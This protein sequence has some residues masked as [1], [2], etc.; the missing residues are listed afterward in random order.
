M[1]TLRDCLP[2]GRCKLPAKQDEISSLADLRVC[3]GDIIDTESLQPR[4]PFPAFRRR[5]LR[6][7]SIHLVSATLAAVPARVASSAPARV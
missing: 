3:R 2:R 7:Y 1:R 4:H 5:Q 6:C